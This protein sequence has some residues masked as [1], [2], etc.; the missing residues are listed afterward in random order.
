MK[1][2]KDLFASTNSNHDQKNIEM[3]NELLKND[4]ETLEGGLESAL[5]LQDSCNAV[6]VA[7]DATKSIVQTL[8]AALEN[9]K[10]AN[11]QE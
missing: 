10:D 6:E 7:R 2:F 9:M 1:T 11:L 4:L 5:N 3:I 8:K